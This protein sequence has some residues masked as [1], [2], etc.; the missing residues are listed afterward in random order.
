MMR[1]T[2]RAQFENIYRFGD[3]YDTLDACDHLELLLARLRRQRILD[4]RQ[5]IETRQSVDEVRAQLAERLQ[6]I[7]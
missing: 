6:R 5:W 7:A 3:V 1:E 2:D 4:E